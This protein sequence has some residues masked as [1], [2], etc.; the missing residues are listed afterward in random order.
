MVR[1]AVGDRDTEATWRTRIRAGE[2]TLLIGTFGLSLL[3]TLYTTWWTHRFK[4]GHYTY[5][6]DCYAKM[7]ASH[8]LPA[9][10][11]RFG[12][13]KAAEAASGFVWSA[14][15]HGGQL[16]M[17]KDVIDKKLDQARIAYSNYYTSLAAKNSRE[18]I[19][20][21]F[22]DLDRCLKGEGTPRGELL[23]P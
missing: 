2:P 16:G 4:E 7:A 8:H 5:A 23:S 22:K 14:E 19:A 17:R 6:M 18:R 10:P 13:F 1:P 21:S 12:S 11:E 3:L 9:R 15:L 20:A